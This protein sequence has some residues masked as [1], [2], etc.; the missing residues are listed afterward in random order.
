MLVYF[1]LTEIFTSIQDLIHGIRIRTITAFRKL[2][3]SYENYN[4]RNYDMNF[5]HK[6]KIFSFLIHY[7][8]TI[9]AKCKINKNPKK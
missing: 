4:N 2:D 1:Y 9:Q 8:N 3:D 7:Y 6:I 5:W